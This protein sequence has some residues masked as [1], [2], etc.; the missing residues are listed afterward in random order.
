MS[1]TSSA[2]SSRN[3]LVIEAERFVGFDISKRTSM[4]AAVDVK[5]QIVLKPR[6]V[7]VER[8]VAWATENLLPTDKVVIE[9]TS[10]AWYYYDLLSPF[11]SGVVVANPHHGLHP[12]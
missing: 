6:K 2:P 9:A 7:N 10:N 11:V 1:I 3:L 5:Q 8:L 4:V 12:F